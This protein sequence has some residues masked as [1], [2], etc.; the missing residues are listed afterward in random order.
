MTFISDFFFNI[1]HILNS[2]LVL[3]QRRKKPQNW[4]AIITIEYW[5]HSALWTR[6]IAKGLKFEHRLIY[7]L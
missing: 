2:S 4:R 5:N 6:Q 3:L 7:A 1:R